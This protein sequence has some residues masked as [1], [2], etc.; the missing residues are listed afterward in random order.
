MKKIK[1]LITL[2]TY[3]VGGLSGMFCFLFCAFFAK[4]LLEAINFIEKIKKIKIKKNF[5]KESRV[6]DHI[7]YVSNIK[8]FKKDYPNWKQKYNTKKILLE[9]IS[10]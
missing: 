4:S 10:N 9:L 3:L 8:K 6:G 2:I 5:I 1:L 7:W